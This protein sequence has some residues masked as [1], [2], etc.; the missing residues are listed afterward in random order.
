MWGTNV[1]KNPARA[2]KIGAKMGNEAVFRNLRPF[3]LLSEL[4]EFFNIMVKAY[5]L[6]NLFRYKFIFIDIEFSC[7]TFCLF[8]PLEPITNVEERLQK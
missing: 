1:L 3:Y 8:A 7:K 5:T 2:S 4:K 6:E